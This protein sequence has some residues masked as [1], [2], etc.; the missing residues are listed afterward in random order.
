[1]IE[2]LNEIWDTTRRNKLR[3]SLT[4]FA[5][6]WGI[7][8]I[9]TLLGA[10]NGLINASMQNNNRWM[11]NS[12]MVIGGVTS[13]PY[14]GFKEG[15][16]LE[17]NDK[18]INT[19]RDVFSGTV[20]NL[21]ATLK[22]S[23][24]KVVYQGEE[25][26][27]SIA[28]VHPGKINIVKLEILAGRFINDIDIKEK[29]KT[30]V[31]RQEAV[32]ELNIKDASKLVGQNVK[33][34][35]LSYKV[36]G[37][38]K[39]KKEYFDDSFYIPFTTY[40]AVYIDSQDKAGTFDFTFDGLNGLK[41]N[42]TFESQYKAKINQNH[43]AAPDDNSALSI[44]N[45]YTQRMKM[46]MGVSILQTALWIIGLFTLLSG[47]VGV[48]NI[49]L[50]TVKERTRE[51][52]I[53]KAIGAKPRQILTLIIVESILITLFFGYI[54]M[55]CGV[56]ANYYMDATLGHDVIDTGLFKATMF[57]DPTV[58]IGT[59]LAATLVMVIAG[60]L[61]GLFPARKAARIRPI[62]ALKG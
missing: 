35:D 15:R 21:S 14:R 23:G 43:D 16:R 13:K 49:M 42:Q 48:S 5:V 41:E 2:I 20:N 22:K 30:V 12:M 51:F 31:L 17:L 11:E 36:V 8:M 1:M 19:T 57:V 10:G 58:K 3:T 54:G 47:V 26:L 29:R 39:E 55:V 50:I 34:G 45:R 24:L 27:G 61:A 28:G 46:N 25:A 18:D 9:I 33:I 40:R 53:R 37:V 52:G 6:A 38:L 60:T 62:E 44:I 56:A 32:K 4:G 59:C 7:F